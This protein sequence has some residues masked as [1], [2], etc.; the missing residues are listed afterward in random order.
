MGAATR[1]GMLTPSSN[2]ALEP[3]TYRMLAAFGD[4]SAHFARIPVTRIDLG[5]DAASQF[6][7]EP[8]LAAAAL[9]ADAKVDVVAWNGTSGSWLGPD[10]DRELAAELSRALGVPATTSTLAL[11]QSFRAYG[12]RRLGLVTPYQ[13]DV[14]AAIT[15]RYAREGVTVVTQRHLGLTD[16]EAFARVGADK[17]TALIRDAAAATV[18]AIAVVCTNLH[19]APLAVEL[20]QKLGVPVLD[21]VTATLWHSLLL[22]GANRPVNGHG[23]LLRSGGTRARLAAVCERLLA[24]TAAD[25]V[26]VRL[27]LA[28]LGLDVERP[29]AQATR[30]GIKPLEAAIPGGQRNLDT[31]T[32]LAE[33]RQPLVQPD[34]SRPPHP[35]A[36]LREAYG[37]KAQMLAPVIR[38]GT[39]TGW[40]SVHSTRPRD[41]R[42]P[43]LASLREAETAVH[44]VIDRLTG[45]PARDRAGPAAAQDSS[46]KPVHS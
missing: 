20:E 3:E 32:W 28:D 36:A 41:W 14:A 23:T 16:N 15:G 2:T 42:Q 13:A 45:V 6:D 25:R 26:T 12:V 21:S 17:L 24:G 39:L 46:D 33:H 34:F 31:I 9:L 10:A 43:D 1:I 29:C 38:G 5:E 44:A 7:P 27:D 18:D 37:V 22:A 4:T 30:Q 19:S 35:P 8:M 40:L 11:L